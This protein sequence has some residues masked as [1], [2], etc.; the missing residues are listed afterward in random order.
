MKYK[1]GVVIY[2][3]NRVDDARINMEIVREV[4]GKSKLFKSIKI[5]HTYNGEKEWYPKKY[6]ED[7]VVRT[8]NTGHF[9]GASKLID[10]GISTL[11]KRYKKLDYVVVLAADTWV[12][13][14]LY[15][16]NTLKKMNKNREYIATC[17]WN[18][19]TKKDP[20]WKLGQLA[21]DMFVV[22][23][24]WAKKYKLFPF[25]YADFFKKYGELVEY[26]GKNVFLENI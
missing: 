1:I 4:W 18:S 2:T 6:I 12:I 21:T 23:A 19:K 25:N 24:V 13:R 17:P 9:S 7:V 20:I 16:A 22:D 10:I 26:Q 3:Y 15:I 11:Q 8:K 5:V 14:P